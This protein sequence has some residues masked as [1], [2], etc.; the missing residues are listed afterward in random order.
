MSLR[1]SRAEINSVNLQQNMKKIGLTL[2]AS[3]NFIM[4]KLT[5]FA[6]FFMF[7]QITTKY[8]TKHAILNSNKTN[9]K[10]QKNYA[11]YTKIKLLQKKNR[12]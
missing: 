8:G 11:R 2:T 10:G 12:P 7:L 5:D 1:A 6:K 9:Q 4:F 3:S